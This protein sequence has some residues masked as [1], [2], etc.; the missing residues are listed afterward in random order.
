[1][2][3]KYMYIGTDGTVWTCVCMGAYLN[4]FLRTFMSMYVYINID[5]HVSVGYV[6]T[7]IVYYKYSYTLTYLY[8][9]TANEI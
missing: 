5:W 9:F 3:V 7:C 8:I 4:I 2:S 1:M 6:Y